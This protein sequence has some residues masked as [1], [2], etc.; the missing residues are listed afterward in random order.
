M[1]DWD[2]LK[3]YERWWLGKKARFYGSDGPFHKVTK[4]KFLGPPS[5][6]YGTVI[7]YFNNDEDGIPVPNGR[8]FKPQK[9]RLEIQK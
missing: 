4:I 2:E 5:G 6:V 7:V 8:S 3:K 9:W 1:T